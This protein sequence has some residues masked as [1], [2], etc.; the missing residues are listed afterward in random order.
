LF[1]DSVLHCDVDKISPSMLITSEDD[2]KYL[3]SLSEL[4][5]EAALADQFDQFDQ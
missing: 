2:E 3:A 1:K 5:F 4:E